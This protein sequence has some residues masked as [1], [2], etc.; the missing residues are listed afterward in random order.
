M[1]ILEWWKSNNNDFQI[2]GKDGFFEMGFL[3]IMI[4]MKTYNGKMKN[5]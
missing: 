3:K 1:L 4:K 2:K 5:L